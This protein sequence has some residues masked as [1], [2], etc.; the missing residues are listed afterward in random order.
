MLKKL[1]AA[2][3]INTYR[4]TPS[5]DVGAAYLAQLAI[6]FPNHIIVDPDAHNIQARVKEIKTAH[7]IDPATGKFSQ[8]LCDTVGSKK[9]MEY[10]TEEVVAPCDLAVGLAGPAL[11]NGKVVSRVYA[12]IGA[13]I[14]R[15]HE[16]DRVT[17]IATAYRNSD[18]SLTF[19]ADRV[20]LVEK[21]EKRST[22]KLAVYMFS[23]ESGVFEMLT[24]DETRERIYGRNPDGSVN[25]NE[26]QPFF[27]AERV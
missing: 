13:E 5:E 6:M 26:I 7:S 20:I 18:S 19:R 1:Y 15:I 10:F 24:V 9:V 21:D 22:D 23:T 14:N 8:K 16:L 17:Y 27:F 12:G 11:V 3:P 2:R 4:G 25:R